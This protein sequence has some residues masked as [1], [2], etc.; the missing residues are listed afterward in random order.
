MPSAS[1][2]SPPPLPWAH[3]GGLSPG[4]LRELILDPAQWTDPERDHVAAC[5]SCRRTF[6][7]LSR[8][9]HPAWWA[10]VEWSAGRRADPAGR[11]VEFHRR[12]CRACDGRLRHAQ[13]LTD[14]IAQA[15][16]PEAPDYDLV[17]FTVRSPD[18][19]LEVDVLGAGPALEVMVRRSAPSPHLTLLGLL[20]RQTGRNPMVRYAVLPATGEVQVEVPRAA[21]LAVTPLADLAWLTPADRAEVAR[22]ALEAGGPAWQAWADQEARRGDATLGP[23]LTDLRDG[24]RNP[25]SS[26]RSVR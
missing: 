1:S 11:S 17:A 21:G 23:W 4:R 19:R 15:A 13:G 8:D 12:T 7:T 25:P 6:E 2:A 3:P 16:F 26:D 20:L 18:L 9:L 10:L 22:T 24:L 14:G 5:T